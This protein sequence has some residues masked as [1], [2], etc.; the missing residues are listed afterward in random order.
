MPDYNITIQDVQEYKK[1]IYN[2]YMIAKI[3]LN[4]ATRKFLSVGYK[5][6]THR[7]SKLKSNS[8]SISIPS[9]SISHSTQYFMQPHTRTLRLTR[10]DYFDD[11]SNKQQSR[12]SSI[13]TGP[14]K[15]FRRRSITQKPR[16]LISQR[17]INERRVESL[18]P[19]TAPPSSPTS[20]FKPDW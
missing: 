1:K 9:D 19:P 5:I 7:E 4:E 16:L 8:V 11:G 13:P 17:L 15:P 18:Q 2:E 6:E 12:R 3:R 10:G 14:P 20:G